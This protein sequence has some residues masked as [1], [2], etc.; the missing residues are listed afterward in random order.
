MSSSRTPSGSGEIQRD[1]TLDAWGCRPRPDGCAR[2]PTSH[3]RPRLRGDGTRPP[4]RRTARG[5]DPGSRRGK[6][7]VVTQIEEEVGRPLVV[8]VLEELD[9]REPEETLVERMVCSTS[10]QISAIWWTP[11]AVEEGRSSVREIGRAQALPL[12][13]AASRSMVTGEEPRRVGS[14]HVGRAG[15]ATPPRRAVPAPSGPPRLQ[16]AASHFPSM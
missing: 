4:P 9:Q 14:Q 12:C 15:S 11:R 8:S 2:R 3:G 6:C 16:R 1:L 13:C 10:E 5:R 7:V